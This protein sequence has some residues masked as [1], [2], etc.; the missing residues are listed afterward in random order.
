MRNGAIATKPYWIADETN[1]FSS[2][3]DEFSDRLTKVELMSI[4]KNAIG[5]T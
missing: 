3:V 5:S 1:G 2:I 4:E